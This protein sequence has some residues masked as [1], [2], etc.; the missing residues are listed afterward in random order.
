MGTAC[1]GLCLRSP[2]GSSATATERFSPQ[3]L[4]Y[5][6]SD[7]YRLG[8]Q[9]SCVRSQIVLI[10]QAVDLGY[11]PCFMAVGAQRIC[12][13][14]TP[15]L[16]AKT[17]LGTAFRGRVRYNSLMQLLCRFKKIPEASPLTGIIP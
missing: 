10:N 2:E 15:I 14:L 8:S 3:I 13:V 5:F 12:A 17:R 16:I 7:Y 4:I 6:C 1:C 11:I 9:N